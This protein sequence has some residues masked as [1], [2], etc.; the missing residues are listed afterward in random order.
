MFSAKL[1]SARAG[2]H[3]CNVLLLSMSFSIIVLFLWQLY[4]AVTGHLRPSTGATF[5]RASS[6]QVRSHISDVTDENIRL[7]MEVH[8]LKT[9]LSVF[10]QTEVQKSDAAQNVLPA[11]DPH[12]PWTPGADRDRTSS[13][14]ELARILRRISVNNEIAVAVSNKFLA[15]DGYMLEGW[16]AI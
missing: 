10:H 11:T 13:N 16:Y 14:P 7:Q 2:V 12:V 3:G 15:M 1:R 5:I 4:G 8:D 6:T 9:R